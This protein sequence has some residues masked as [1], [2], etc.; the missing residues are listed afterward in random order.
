MYDPHLLQLIRLEVAVF[1]RDAAWLPPPPYVDRA[2][3]DRHLCCLYLCGEI[4]GRCTIGRD[5][6]EVE[7]TGLTPYG[8]LQLACYKSRFDAEHGPPMVG[9]VPPIRRLTDPGDPAA[10]SRRE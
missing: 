4:A 2:A 8:T 3:R 7:P 6:L 9:R 1:G 5:G 10:A